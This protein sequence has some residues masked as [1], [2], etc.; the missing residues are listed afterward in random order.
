MITAIHH[1]KG[2]TMIR[3]NPAWIDKV[4]NEVEKGTFKERIVNVP[5]AAKWLVEF[6]ACNGYVPKVINLGVGVKNYDS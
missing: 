4:K 3:I 5:A 6:L 2:S 1:G